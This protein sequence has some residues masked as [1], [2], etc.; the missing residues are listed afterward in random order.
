MTT[1]TNRNTKGRNMTTEHRNRKLNHSQ[2]LLTAAEARRL[3][4]LYSTDGQ[5]DNARAI[6]HYFLGGFDWFATE[7]DPETGRFF[8]LCYNREMA[9]QMPE[10]ELG[11]FTADDLCTA[12]ATVNVTGAVRG[13]FRQPVERDLWY[14]GE[15]LGEIRA[16]LNPQ[17]GPELSEA[18]R[19]AAA[20]FE[21][22]RDAAAEADPEPAPQPKPVDPPRGVVARAPETPRRPAIKT[23][24]DD[25]RRA[26]IAAVNC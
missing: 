8:G 13:S 2:K 15:T 14:G 24:T 3:P 10:G 9:D 11:Y 21:A 23:E 16:R 7:Y 19:E 6:V 25:D 22:D 26:I 18:D 20:I 1:T 17:R 5:G 12:A 4:A